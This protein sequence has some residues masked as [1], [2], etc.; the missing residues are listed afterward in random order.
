MSGERAHRIILLLTSL[1]RPP[2]SDSLIKASSGSDMMRFTFP[3]KC[4]TDRWEGTTGT[5]GY[6]TAVSVIMRVFNM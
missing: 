2:R 1:A 3:E 4:S 5:A 6:C